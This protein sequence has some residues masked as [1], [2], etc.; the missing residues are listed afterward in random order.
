MYVQFLFTLFSHNLSSWLLNRYKDLI[1]DFN[2]G[3]A[4]AVTVALPYVSLYMDVGKKMRGSFVVVVI[5]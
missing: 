2:S 3:I 5:H 1:A 4:E